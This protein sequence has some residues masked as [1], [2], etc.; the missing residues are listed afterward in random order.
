MRSTG[1]GTGRARRGRTAAAAVAVA[2]GLVAC[3]EPVATET[4]GLTAEDLQEVRDEVADLEDR[5]ATLED[6]L[7]DSSP[8]EPV[9]EPVGEPG[10][11]AAED[12][13]FGDPGS[14]VGQQVTVRGEVAELLTSSQ[15]ASAFRIAGDVGEPV[16][17][18]S[19]TPPP[20]IA[21]GDVVEVSGTAVEVDPGTFERDFG[22]AAD[23]L[24]DD[25]GAWFAGAEGRV[26]IAA[27][28]IEVL[29]AAAG[30]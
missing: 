15:V 14:S 2:L 8:P 7:V 12:T 6:R 11:P 17:V 4:P 27:V 21:T 29:Q 16:A 22:I 24:F 20:E 26:A 5:V 9:D 3:S 1:A 30:D 10:E 25:P 19:V 18:V 13:F 28:R 23:E